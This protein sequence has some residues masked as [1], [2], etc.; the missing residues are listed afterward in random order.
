[1]QHSDFTIDLVFWSAD[2][3]HFP[4]RVTDIGRRT[5]IAM[6]IDSE[7]AGLEFFQQE[8][9]TYIEHVFA[10]DDL[11]GCTIERVIDPGKGNWSQRFNA[12]EDSSHLSPKAEESIG[13]AEESI[14]KGEESAEE[15]L[16][17]VS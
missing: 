6:Q 17:T 16:Y 7:K 2:R 3:P 1:M 15:P 14:G 10:E 11:A 12:P 4:W 13:K 5:I 8:P 9:R